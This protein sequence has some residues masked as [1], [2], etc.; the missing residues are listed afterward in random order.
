MHGDAK[1]CH[2]IGGPKFG[3]GRL[4]ENFSGVFRKTLKVWL[5]PRSCQPTALM[6]ADPSVL[7]K[8]KPV[9]YSKQ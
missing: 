1:R 8:Q 2:G 4:R 9:H 6:V 7:Q 3:I 5:V